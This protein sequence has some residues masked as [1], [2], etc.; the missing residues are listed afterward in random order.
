[1]VDVHAPRIDGAVTYTQ[2]SIA[3]SYEQ[4]RTLPALAD[5]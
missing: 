4:K 2:A 5:K 3:V 1:M